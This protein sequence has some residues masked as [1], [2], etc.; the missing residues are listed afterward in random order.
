ML[1]T[2][3]GTSG[4]LSNIQQPSMRRTS[5]L[6]LLIYF[7]DTRRIRHSCVFLQT[8]APGGPP[9]PGNSWSM[10]G[11][12]FWAISAASQHTMLRYDAH[13]SNTPSYLLWPFTFTL[14][15]LSPKKRLTFIFLTEPG[16]WRSISNYI[17]LVH[18]GEHVLG[19]QSCSPTYPGPSMRRAS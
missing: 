18:V 11:N 5:Q 14:F 12:L 15:R 16:P 2:C 3:F 1:G 19:H 10:L 17:L 9:V 7:D 13:F 8:L 4:L 6:C